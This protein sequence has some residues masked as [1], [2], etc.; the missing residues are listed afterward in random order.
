MDLA[1][2]AEQCFRCNPWDK[3]LPGPEPTPSEPTPRVPASQAS[4]ALSLP[5]LPSFFIVLKG[6]GDIGASSHMSHCERSE[7]PPWLQL[8][9]PGAPSLARS[10]RDRVGHR[11]KL[12]RFSFDFASATHLRNLI[13]LHQKQ[14]PKEH[15]A[16]NQL[17]SRHIPLLIRRRPKR[18]RHHEQPPSTLPT[19]PPSAPTPAPAPIQS[20]GM[21]YPNPT[22]SSC[23]SGD[24]V[25]CS[26]FPC[27]NAP[28][29]RAPE[30][31]AA[32]ESSRPAPSAITSTP[33]AYSVTLIP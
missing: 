5:S 29:P 19:S 11:A 26:A 8:F 2:V 21:Q 9:V 24:F 4:A 1:E 22:T 12:D 7:E 23:S 33:A 28:R 15:R 10:Y 30:T 32:P 3:V 31:R 14:Q 20:K 25:I 16:I 27:T 6:E 13:P 18:Q 17:L